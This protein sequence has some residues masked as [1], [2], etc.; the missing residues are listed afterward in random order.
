MG[1]LGKNSAFI[2]LLTIISPLI[3]QPVTAISTT[4]SNNSQRNWSMSGSDPCHDRVGTDSF[5]TNSVNIPEQI[6]QSN[7]KWEKAPTEFQYRGRSLTEPIVV[8]G[9]VYVGA[10]SHVT[11]DRYH[12]QAWTDIYAL[13]ASNGLMIWDF[14]DN[15]SS[16]LTP[17]AVVNGA[18]FFANGNYIC[19]LNAKDGSTLWTIPASSAVIS[20]PVIVQNELFIDGKGGLL[21]L[22]TTNGQTIWKYTNSSQFSTPAV[23]NGM[24]YVGS[25]DENIYGLNMSTGE[26]IWS[27][28]SGDFHP[29][30]AVADEIVYGITSEANIYA[31]NA[32]QGTKIWNYSI[33][34]GWATDDQPYFAISSGLLYARNGL[35]K[36]YA[37]NALSGNKIWYKTFENSTYHGIS[38][39]TAVNGVVY[40]GTDTGIYALKGNSGEV[41]WNYSTPS[42]F[43]PPVI[44]NGVLY[45]TSNEQVYAIQIPSST[46]EPNPESTIIESVSVAVAATVLILIIVI[47][48]LLYR[49]HRK[50]AKKPYKQITQTLSHWSLSLS[51]QLHT[52]NLRHVLKSCLYQLLSVFYC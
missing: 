15:S 24:V 22:N 16:R 8:D 19:S 13:N 25:F 35:N 3:L 30:P 26:K 7:L 34:D 20:Y 32:R 51:K 14:R 17:P 42:N 50:T 1:S 52:I 9:V 40:L 43:G 18:V 4:S 36:I 37:I 5:T 41:V 47:S 31:F 21:A 33:Y 23:A 39:P 2:L 10:S 48:A 6:W 27:Y 28:H 38:A 45:A 12:G 49:R 46:I 44:V 11:I 29:E